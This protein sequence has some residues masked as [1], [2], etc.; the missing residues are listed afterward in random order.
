MKRHLRLWPLVLVLLGIAVLGRLLPVQRWALDFASYVRE[1]GALGVGLYSFSYVLGGILLVPSAAFTT[2][3]GFAYGPWAAVAIGIPAGT[4]AS[5]IVFWLGRTALRRQVA[6][7]L[8]T[9]PKGRLFE[10]LVERHG[11]RTVV[12]LR[13]SPIT[14][15][16]VLNYA[17][18]VTQISVPQ[19][20]L[21]SLVG[22]TPG[23]LLY[24]HLGALATDAASLASG[25]LPT[26]TG[27]GRWILWL[28]TAATLV[29][30][31]WLGYLAR[32]LLREVEQEPQGLEV[33]SSGE[34]DS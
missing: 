27:G 9:H 17:F 34:R 13:L 6:E 31:I 12:L 16:N 3:A 10:K 4:L 1:L 21:A 23:V 8:S 22:I 29:A 18:G 32:R 14:P 33:T 2:A 20:A 28:G 7:R 5:V 19:Y 24:A 11:A 15:F 30:V 26:A 25:N